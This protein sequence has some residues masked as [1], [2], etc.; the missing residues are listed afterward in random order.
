MAPGQ[1][2]DIADLPTELKDD[3]AKPSNVG[4]WQ[5][6]LAIEVMSA[7]LRDEQNIFET[8]THEFERTLII[9]ALQHTGGRRIEAANQLGMGRIS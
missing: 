7:L 5:E 4:S 3:V 8:L 9:K 1:N 2:I 6:A